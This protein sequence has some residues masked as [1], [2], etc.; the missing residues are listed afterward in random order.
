MNTAAACTYVR[1]TVGETVARLCFERG[2]SQSKLA[3]TISTDRSH[4]NQIV[5]GKHSV[6]LDMLVR[7]AEGLEV[8]L[9]GLFVGLEGAPP[10][11]LA[12]SCDRHRGASRS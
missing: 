4:L 6:T 3:A 10:H 5:N 9:T 11:E 1:R 12:L 8:P 2:I 7:I